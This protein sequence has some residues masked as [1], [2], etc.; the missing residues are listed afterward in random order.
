QTADMIIFSHPNYRLRKL[1]RH[2]HHEWEFEDFSFGKFAVDPPARLRITKDGKNGVIYCVS[3]LKS[4]SE[5]SIAS[6]TVATTVAT[7]IGVPVPDYEKLNIEQCYQLW[8]TQYGQEWPAEWLIFG[9]SN[10]FLVYTYLYRVLGFSYPVF[11]IENSKESYETRGPDGTKYKMRTTDNWYSVAVQ[12]TNAGY[13]GVL[14]TM[15]SR[16][17]EYVTK[18]NDNATATGITTLQWNAVKDAKNYNVYR[19]LSKA[20]PF[21]F[22]GN[23]DKTT[24]T[25]EAMPADGSR[26]PIQPNNPFAGAND[27]PGVSILYEQRLVLARSNDKPTTFWGSRTGVYDDFSVHSPLQDDD[28]YSYTLSSGEMNEI[29]WALP[30][31]EILFGTS[32]GEFKAGGG[33]YAITPTNVNARAQSFY[34]CAPVQPVIVGRS[35]VFVGRS[36]QVLRDMSYSLDKDGFDGDDLTLYATHLFENRTIVEICHQQEPV[37]VLWLVMSDGALLSCVYLPNQQVVAW[38]R[39]STQ[40]RFTACASLVD[41]DGTDRVYFCV[42]RLINGKQRRYIEVMQSNLVPSSDLTRAYFVDCGLTYEGTPTA[43]LAG[44]DH[45]EGCEVEILADGSH[46]RA[47]VD[48]G[49]ITLPHAAAIIHVGLGYAAA[50]ETLDMQPIQQPIKARPHIVRKVEIDLEKTVSCEVGPIGGPCDETIRAQGDGV[51]RLHTG[52]FVI[53]PEA[54]K[55]DNGYRLRFESD[56]PYPLCILAVNAVGDI[57]GD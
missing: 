56:R 19:A 29:Y 25:D 50:M 23:T 54:P 22:L 21:R 28:S 49:R 36:R 48:N 6:D 43:S 32:G 31:N 24:F 40:G 5:E 7:G 12:Y 46:A 42:T 20:E 57:G 53:F 38:S 44:L 15:R 8:V 17:E 26:G 33:G 1:I 10:S 51:P 14:K 47:R 13:G 9:A 11:V 30:L 18:F 34:G 3:A 4:N 37:S 27:N 52:R 45:L 35:A 41:T 2:D 39:H 16:I 55:D